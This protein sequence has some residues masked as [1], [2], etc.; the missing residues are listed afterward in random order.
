VDHALVPM[1]AGDGL[2]A[3]ALLTAHLRGWLGAWPPHGAVD[4]VGAPVRDQPAW[5]GSI[6]PLVGVGTPDQ[7]LLSVTPARAE[8][9]RRA[10]GPLDEEG[11]RKAIVKALGID[12]Y[13]LGR[14]VFRWT[15]AVAPPDVLPD[16]GEW[17]DPGDPRVPPWLRPFNY[18][19]VLIAWDDDGTYG[20]GV[21]IKRHDAVGHELAV[22]TSEHLRGRGIGRRLVAQAARRIL[23]DGKLPT[24]LHGPANIASARVADAVGFA[25]RGWSVYGLF[26]AASVT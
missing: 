6:A 23:A 14:G 16:A 20:A 22:V 8:H 4:I 17:L 2:E 19:R 5:D 7:T 24:Y 15:T 9:V 13:V 10:A 21:G 12:G 18:G 1:P 26:P 3:G 11:V 25:D